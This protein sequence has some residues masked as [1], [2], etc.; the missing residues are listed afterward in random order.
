M[1]QAEMFFHDQNIKK[2]H[3]IRVAEGT[4]ESPI[5][6]IVFVSSIPRKTKNSIIFISSKKRLEP[7]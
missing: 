4:I 1:N 5:I 7:Y 6:R 2:I 3:T